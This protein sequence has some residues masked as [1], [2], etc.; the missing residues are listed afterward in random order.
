[1]R[2][3]LILLILGVFSL[4]IAQADPFD[5][6]LITANGNPD[7]GFQLSVTVNNVGGNAEFVFTNNGP[8]PSIITAVYFDSGLLDSIIDIPSTDGVRFGVGARPRNLPGRNGT[9]FN[10]DLSA[11][12]FAGVNSGVNPGET[13]TIVISLAT[14]GTFD[15]L[16]AS[17]ENEI[18]VGI[19]VQS[20][21]GGGSDSYVTGLENTPEPATLLLLGSG[22]LAGGLRFRKKFM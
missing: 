1:M 6:T 21:N 17:M 14:G 10:A 3:F 20:I 16:I 7:I 18:V 9:G 15:S 8:T 2:K 12:R 13:L 11:G 22:L 4:G 5:F 19:H